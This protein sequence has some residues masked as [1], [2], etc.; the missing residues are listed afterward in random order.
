MTPPRK[1]SEFR[2][3]EDCKNAHEAIEKSREKESARLKWLMGLLFV[4]G[5]TWIGIYARANAVRS[6]IETGQEVSI[7]RLQSESDA[8]TKRLVRIEDKLDMLI[9]N[10]PRKP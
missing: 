7:G 6:T 8:V 10:Q 1:P 3:I 5:M 2:A 4:I 9:L